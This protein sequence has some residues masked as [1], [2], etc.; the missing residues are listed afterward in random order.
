MGHHLAKVFGNACAAIG[1]D[2]KAHMILAGVFEQKERYGI[3][4]DGFNM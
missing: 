3:V 2:F 4:M 1:Q